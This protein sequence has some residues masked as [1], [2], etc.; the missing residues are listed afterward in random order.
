MKLLNSYIHRKHLGHQLDGKLSFSKHT[1]NK[2][3]KA[4]KDI[5]LLRQ[6][7]PILHKQLKGSSCDELYQELGLDCNS[8]KDTLNP[9]CSC[10]IE[11]ETPI[12]DFMCYHFY[13]S[14]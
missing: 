8:F 13:N 3:S 1:D 11:V 7:Q 12:R 5:G 2:I 6:L 10:S 4:T 14:D 9:L